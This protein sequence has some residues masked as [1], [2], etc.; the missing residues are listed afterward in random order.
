[1]NLFYD[2]CNFK[3]YLVTGGYNGKKNIVSTE[4]MSSSGSSWSYVGN[5]PTAA[6]GLRGIS[7]NNQIFVTGQLYEIIINSGCQINPPVNFK[8]NP[9]MGS[10][11]KIDD[12]ILFPMKSCY[13]WIRKMHYLFGQNVNSKCQNT[14]FIGTETKMDDS[15][16]LPV[17]SSFIFW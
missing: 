2:S 13:Y 4:V 12:S 1:M 3:I 16:L 7:V 9:L 11:T 14:P 10:E 8:N 5:L 17:K 15:I 6:D